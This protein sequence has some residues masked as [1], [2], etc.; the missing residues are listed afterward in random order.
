MDRRDDLKKTG[1]NWADI[2]GRSSKLTH[3]LTHF[4]IREE[5]KLVFSGSYGYT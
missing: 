3:K 2:T 4:H 1:Q 5:E